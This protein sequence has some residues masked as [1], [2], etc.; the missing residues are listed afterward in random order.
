[1]D[2]RDVVTALISVS[3]VVASVGVSFL[4]TRRNLLVQNRSL[5]GSLLIQKRFEYYPELY[6]V[7]SSFIKA[8]RD[9]PKGVDSAPISVDMFLKIR[10]YLLDWDSKYSYLM[11]PKCVYL[12][13]V[14]YTMLKEC[15]AEDDQKLAAYLNDPKKREDIAIATSRVESVLKSDLGVYDVASLGINM[16]FS[17]YP[18]EWSKSWEEKFYWKIIDWFPWAVSFK[19]KLL[20]K[21]SPF[22]NL[23][24]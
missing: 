7:L 13:T 3:G 5:F 12:W 6:Q 16:F 15:S 2:N 22:K 11:S 24:K 14:Y 21:W 20:P 8:L 18:D 9:T 17:D 1:M 4:V 19:R 23:N 10:D